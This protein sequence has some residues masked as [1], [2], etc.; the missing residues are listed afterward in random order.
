[1]VHGGGKT[2]TWIV[3]SIMGSIV[4]DAMPSFGQ[5]V[6]DRSLGSESSTVST[7]VPLGNDITKLI[8]GGAV[9]GN[10]L[11]HS[12]QEF[13]VNNG[14]QVYFANP[15]SIDHIIGRVTG[16]NVSEIFGRLGVLGNA[17]LFLLNPQGFVFGPNASL[18]I[19]GAFTAS[20]SQS[21]LLGNGL[22]F[23][24]T[25]PDSAPL[26]TINQ[27]PGLGDWLNP[28]GAIANQGTLSVGQDLTLVGKTLDL[29]GELNAG[30]NLT[31]QASESLQIRDRPTAPSI[32][33]AGSQI[34]IEAPEN[35][36]ITVLNHPDSGLFSGGDMIFRSAN[37]IITDAYFSS[38]GNFRLEQMNGDLGTA[39]SPGDPIIRASGNV[40][41]DNYSGASLH[42]LAGGS[43]TINNIEITGAEPGNSIQE[44]V[45]LSDGITTVAIDGNAQPTVDIRAGTT[46]FNPPG[47][48]G[49]STGLSSSL[50]TTGTATSAAISIN[51]IVNPGG[52]VFLTNQDRSNQELS[53][54]IS[55][56]SI[57]GF[58]SVNGASVFINSKGGI[59]INQ[60]IEVSG[61]SGNAGDVFLLAEGDISLPIEAQVLAYGL[62]GVGGNI[63]LKSDSAI[64]A[65]YLES[66]TFGEGTGGDIRMIAPQ[67]TIGDPS[68]TEP[69]TGQLG[70][71]AAVLL[72]KGQGGN[73]EIEADRLQLSGGNIAIVTAE[74]SLG[75]SG[76][77]TINADSIVLDN[78]SLVVAVAMSGNG[79]DT[80]D[81]E[82]ETNNLTIRDGS[83]LN[84][85]LR[86]VGN[87]GDVKVTATDS[88]NITGIL[89]IGPSAIVNEVFLTGIGNGGAIEIQ[90]GSLT[91]TEGGQIRSSTNGTGNSGPIKI[92]ADNAIRID[93]FAAVPDN[94]ESPFINSL[95]ISG[96]RPTAVGNGNDIT[97]TTN[98]LIA[99]NGGGITA[100]TQG[101]G[102]SGNISIVANEFAV[103]EGDPSP[104]S[105]LRERPFESGAFVAVL[106][107]ENAEEDTVTIGNG[108]ILTIT[109]PYLSVLNGAQ[110][111]SE[112]AT[113]AQ[114]NTGTIVLNVSD[115]I[116]LSGAQTGLFSNTEPE[117]TGNGGSI[118]IDPERLE[119]KDGAGISVDS[120]GSGT[121]GRVEIRADELILENQG[122]IS[123]ETASNNGGDITLQVPDLL[124]LREGS[125]IST[126][127]GTSGAGG[128]G[129][130]IRISTNVLAT[131]PDENNDIA[132]N[133]FLGS[134]GNVDI[135]TEGIFGFNFPE[136]P[137]PF[138]DITASS[139]FG[140]SGTVVLNNPEVDPSSG[141]VELSDKVSD[142][143]DKLLVGCAVAE[144]NSFT[145]TGR[146][147]LPED[148]TAPLGGQ[149]LLSD[150]RDFVT[151]Q[152]QEPSDRSLD[153][154]ISSIR[155]APIIVEANSWAI[156][157][158]GTIELVTTL[159]QETSQKN[160]Y[161][162]H[163]VSH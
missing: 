23:S 134:G 80:G 79:G 35:L 33:F 61:E 131:I 10:S 45:T 38:G 120:Q 122:F 108:G 54:E 42:I 59:N 96:V 144:E 4:A 26:L 58:G 46:N 141:L 99:S 118:F 16:S 36:E 51:N 100:S 98:R 162:C 83:Q 60:V 124:L 150:V 152:N 86:G 21:L 111:R 116:L 56:N 156:N 91:I 93:G 95:I 125:R 161:I 153:N 40:S 22:E 107:Q 57:N 132:A 69:P 97:I 160:V 133:A 139:Q 73:V 67:I 65:T 70:S 106:A 163:N 76:N 84:S 81:I 18:D 6:P 92:T 31:L 129:G 3:L 89:D 103:F 104:L 142:P 119:I 158:Q 75:D 68:L 148:P 136:Q 123:A 109:T 115:S 102:N 82:V 126:T 50:N 94:T 112:L 20:A 25:N 117:T 27:S 72:G 147:G 48:T 110:L 64:N 9:R 137:T 151:R 30:N 24:A 145:V 78:N 135:T 62:G 105:P 87:N 143:S 14:Q 138:S 74:N 1:M 66:I 49:S 159:P 2:L 53:G 63:T 127:A 154:S 140:V 44:N 113:G 32:A 37:T 85:Q 19:S 77:M 55:V 71:I 88:I 52:L 90:T 28:T 47:I 157:E 12:F 155:E 7:N 29:S 41:F 39:K 130:N 146:G 15:T 128:N 43:V 8:E 5:I 101:E 114:G 13:N 17:N 121:G 34:L 11:F 149:T